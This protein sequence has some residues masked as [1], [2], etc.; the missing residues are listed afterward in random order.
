MLTAAHC[1]QSME[2]NSY[3]V[4]VGGEGS[5]DPSAKTVA[6]RKVHTHPA[7]FGSL[8]NDLAI[9]ELSEELSMSFSASRYFVTTF[10]YLSL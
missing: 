9:L 4:Y 6:V 10:C 8:L 7:Y 3:Q 5:K 2:K 1:V